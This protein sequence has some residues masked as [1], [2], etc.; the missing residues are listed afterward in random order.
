[1][2]SNGIGKLAITD[3]ID[4][5]FLQEFQDSFSKSM[6]IA[7]VTVDTEG[8]PVTKPSNYVRFCKKIQSTAK[9]EARCADSH[10]KGG[11]EAVRTGKPYIYTCNSGLI[12]FAAPVIVGGQHIGTVLGGQIFYSRNDENRV[13][14]IVSDLDLPRE[15][16]TGNLNSVNIVEEERVKAAADVLYTVT[17]TIGTVGYQKMKMHDAAN[18]FVDNFEQIS[19][20]MEQL[21]ASS[22]G[23]TQNQEVL[24]K[25]IINVK[26]IAGEIN[27]ILAQIKSIADQSK[28]LGL[29]AAIEAARAGEIGKGFGVVAAEMRKLSESSK[30]TAIKAGNLTIQ[31]S[32]TVDKTLD[33]SKSTLDVTAQQS[34]A[35]E[36]TNASIEEV[37]SMAEELTRLT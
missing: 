28:M 2:E 4:V 14:D 35:I 20:A 3:V 16:Y 21:S 30:E 33:V 17:N 18:S 1:M 12:D 36:E 31:I 9:G 8:K 15:E 7:A 22:I 34:A 29:N 6:G 23:V 10:K 32:K 25:E 27:E 24:N 37:T 13:G 26:E 11:E 19:A 5:G